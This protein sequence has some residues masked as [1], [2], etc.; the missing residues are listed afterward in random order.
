MQ[1]TKWGV[2]T[3]IAWGKRLSALVAYRSHK[4]GL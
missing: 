4:Y 2:T 3:V 1:D